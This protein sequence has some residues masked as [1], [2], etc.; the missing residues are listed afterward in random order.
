M[1]DIQA[2]ILQQLV[3]I[4]I[5]SRSRCAILCRGL[6]GLV[7]DNIA[8]CG[9]FHMLIQAQ[10][11]QMLAVCN[12]SASNNANSQPFAHRYTSKSIGRVERLTCPL[13]N[14]A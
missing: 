13:A 1:N 4:R 11:R 10:G 9:Q 6:L 14:V 12:A 2:I 8:E 5:N 7:L 3:I